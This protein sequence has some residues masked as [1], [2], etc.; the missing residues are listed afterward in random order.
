LCYLNKCSMFVEY[1]VVIE[2]YCISY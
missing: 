1:H 2:I